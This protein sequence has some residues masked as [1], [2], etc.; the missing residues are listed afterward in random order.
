MKSAAFNL[1]FKVHRGELPFPEGLLKAVDA[2]AQED[3]IEALNSLSGESKYDVGKIEQMVEE[4]KD[5]VT[6][7]DQKPKVDLEK[8]K[9]ELKDLQKKR[10]EFKE[11]IRAIE[12]QISGLQPTIVP[13]INS[14][15]LLIVG[16]I[17]FLLLFLLEITYV[18]VFTAIATV[19][20]II[21]LF[22]QDLH[23][24]NKQLENIQQRKQQGQ[25]EIKRIHS[26]LDELNNQISTVQQKIND[27][28]PS[29]NYEENQPDNTIEKKSS[30]Q[31]QNEV[32][33]IPSFDNDLPPLLGGEEN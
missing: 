26:E 8:L 11:R 27:A 18:A 33:K 2:E 10:S 25:D 12:V 24:Y 31:E 3:Y 6:N 22:A 5:G 4:A 16:G 28:D 29:A 32:P 23:S 15:M 14:I 1:A 9:K 17:I 20:G 30:S 21:F 19:L 7:Q 13:G